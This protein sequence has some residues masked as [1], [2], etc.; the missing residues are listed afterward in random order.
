MSQQKVIGSKT[1]LNENKYFNLIDSVGYLG[2]E[3]LSLTFPL[4]SLVIKNYDRN[5]NILIEFVITI[6]FDI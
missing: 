5:L 3:Q 4:A 2:H 1:R 6:S